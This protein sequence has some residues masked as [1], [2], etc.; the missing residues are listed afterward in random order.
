MYWGSST[1]YSSG[2]PTDCHYKCS[3]RNDDE[4][5]IKNE[6]CGLPMESGRGGSNGNVVIGNGNVVKGSNNGVKGD[7]NGVDGHHNGVDGDSNSV[8]GLRNNVQGDNKIV[9]G[10]DIEVEDK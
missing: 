9:V 1:P 10:N 7:D 2:F 8:H 4:E 3:Y 6:Y 5:K